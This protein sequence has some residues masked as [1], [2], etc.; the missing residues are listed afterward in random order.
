M[1][2]SSL[3][4]FAGVFLGVLGGIAMTTAFAFW[5][6]APCSKRQAQLNEGDKT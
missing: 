2:N 5:L 1:S 6:D 3:V 4:F